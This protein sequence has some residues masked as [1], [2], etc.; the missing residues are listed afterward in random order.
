MTNVSGTDIDEIS[1]IIDAVVEHKS[2]LL[3]YARYCPTIVEKDVGIDPGR[4]RKL[5]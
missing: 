3:A 5:L 1:D 4:Y 2:D